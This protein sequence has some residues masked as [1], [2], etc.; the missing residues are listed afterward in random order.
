MRKTWSF[1]VK[2][3]AVKVVN[4]W[5]R[6][7]KLYIDGDFK[8]HDG[9]FF[10]FGREVMLSAGLGDEGVLEIEPTAY[11][12]VEIDVYLCKDNERTLVFSSTRRLP[13]SQQREMS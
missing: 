8:D 7:I 6:G 5:F 1:K 10:A 2:G 11:V 12:S 4:S 3:H 9:S 13:L